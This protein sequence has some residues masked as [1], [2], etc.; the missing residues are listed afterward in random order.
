MAIDGISRL[1]SVTQMKASNAND[2]AVAGA[3]AQRDLVSQQ[4]LLRGSLQGF[5]S[6]VAAPAQV[7]QPGVV[8]KRGLGL[9]RVGKEIDLVSPQVSPFRAFKSSFGDVIK[10]AGPQ[11]DTGQRLFDLRNKI[12]DTKVSIANTERLLAD[13][14]TSPQNKPVLEQILSLQKEKLKLLEAELAQLEM[15]Q[16]TVRPDGTK[17][18]TRWPSRD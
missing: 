16:K 12:K 6:K 2:A 4:K 13:P 10:L 18:P 15:K 7:K 1:I 11:S 9:D 5:E 3:A 14:N 17:A 8:V